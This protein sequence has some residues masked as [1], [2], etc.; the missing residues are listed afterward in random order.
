MTDNMDELIWREL[1][2]CGNPRCLPY[3]DSKWSPE[4]LC[5]A[6]STSIGCVLAITSQTIASTLD[7]VEAEV[8][9]PD[10]P[11]V[12]QSTIGT[13]GGI[14]YA[15]LARNGLRTRQR[16]AITNIRKELE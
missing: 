3:K 16:Q 13:I 10:E 6:C 11:A 14:N 12:F 1:P 8:L 9:E 7:R 2:T 15:G 5:R 4:A